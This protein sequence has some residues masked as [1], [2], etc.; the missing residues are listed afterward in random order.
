MKLT[1]LQRYTAYII[2]L[3]EIDSFWKK[4]F[5][6]ERGL[7]WL[8]FKTFGIENR[9][10]TNREYHDGI[11]K[12]L[13]RFPELKQMIDDYRPRIEDKETRKQYLR[14]CITLTHP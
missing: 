13:N 12:V 7:C 11:C 5:C 1:K 6:F 8:I 3:E 2:M 10:F 4:Q 9:G 14:E